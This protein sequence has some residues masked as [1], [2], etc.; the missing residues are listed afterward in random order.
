M[1]ETWQEKTAKK[2]AELESLKK[3]IDEQRT[4]GG[5]GIQGGSRF[6]SAKDEL[7]AQLSSIKAGLAASETSAMVDDDEVDEVASPNKPKSS[8]TGMTPPW[9][10]KREQ[11]KAK[12]QSYQAQLRI[13]QSQGIA[14]RLDTDEDDDT[15]EPAEERAKKLQDDIKRS[16]A[17]IQKIKADEDHVD[18]DGT[19]GGSGSVPPEASRKAKEG[20]GH[21]QSPYAGV[22]PASDNFQDLHLS[23]QR[24]TA[25]SG[26]SVEPMSL[27]PVA[28]VDGPDPS[29]R[30]DEDDPVMI[31]GENLRQVYASAGYFAYGMLFF[32]LLCFIFGIFMPWGFSAWAIALPLG[33]ASG[34][35]VR[36]CL[37]L[38][39]RDDNGMPMSLACASVVV[40][41]GA[42]FL[43]TAGILSASA[44]LS[45]APIIGTPVC[46]EGIPTLS[47][48]T[49]NSSRTVATPA[50]REKLTN[51][52]TNPEG[53]NPLSG[54]DVDDVL[55]LG[56]CQA[57]NMCG[58]QGIKMLD[59]STLKGFNDWNSVFFFLSSLLIPALWSWIYYTVSIRLQ[60]NAEAMNTGCS[61]EPIDCGLIACFWRLQ[62]Y[63]AFVTTAEEHE[64]ESDEENPSAKSE[65][66]PKF[67]SNGPYRAE[68]ADRSSGRLSARA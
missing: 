44:S 57:W 18:A 50:P 22:Y 45:I 12:L 34:T 9:S 16:V 42:C 58:A 7:K 23:T 35:F 19:G 41:Y 67:D 17:N 10:S 61:F 14:R 4:P 48:V 27:K 54:L 39:P 3:L 55:K 30:V 36:Y 26:G 32:S 66:F 51:S 56:G 68:S 65:S 47:N 21:V 40:I 43:F 15:S 13:A 1:D 8:D 62:E 6:S 49:S 2:I 28:V 46:N 20:K 31:A 29:F 25:K 11:L 64:V 38:P 53:P 37:P 59:C 60:E 63:L 33:L 24:S 5:S 52:A